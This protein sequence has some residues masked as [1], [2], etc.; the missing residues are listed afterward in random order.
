MNPPNFENQINIFQLSCFSGIVNDMIFAYNILMLI[1][2]F[3]FN[4]LDV[5]AFICIYS[6]YLELSDLTKLQD[7]ARLKVILYADP[8]NRWNDNLANDIPPT[9]E[10]P[11][12][13][14]P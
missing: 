14:N 2:W 1:V 8:E 7:L 9:N 4:I 13:D 12:K 10:N 5:L 6:L 3:F 11:L